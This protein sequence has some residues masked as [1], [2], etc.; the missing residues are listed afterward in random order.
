MAEIIGRKQ[1]IE[2]LNRLYHSDRAQFVAVY[3]RRRVGKTYLINQVFK[4]RITFHH[5]GLSPFDNNRKSTMKDQLQAFHYSLIRSGMDESTPCPKS[6]FE[7]FFLLERWLVKND[8]GQ[9]QVVFID[10]LPWMDTPRS[11]FLSALESFWNG[12]ASGCDNMFLVVCGS[13]TSW[14][15]SNLVNNYGGL[16]GRLTYE[17]KLSPFTLKECHDYL[18]SNGIKLGQYD[19]TQAYMVFGGIPYYLGYFLPGLSLAQNVDRLLFAKDAILAKEYD[20]LFHSLF[21]HWEEH[22]KVVQLLSTRHYGF[23]RDEISEHCGISKGGGLSSILKAL[24]DSDFIMKYSPVVD[25]RN[26]EYYRLCD[27][28]CL[29]YLKFV[30]D[31]KTTD[32]QFWQNNQNLQ[33]I[34]SWRGIAFEYVCFNHIAQIKRALGVSGVASRESALLVKGTKDLQGGQIDLLIDRADNVLNLCEMKFYKKEFSVTQSD[35]FDFEERI[36]LLNRLTK[37]KKNIHFTLVTTVGLAYNEH[38]GV[39]QKVVTLEDLFK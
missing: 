16:Y 9:R 26:V 29:F 10:E 25:E 22:Q 20:R 27:P 11:R 8:S 31:N 7:A 23:T 13:S 2:E 34:V 5:T 32:E 12:W 21:V 4:D 18:K 28:F 14:M 19:V 3:G 33:P 36:E 35:R 39:V 6:W 38:S 30:A 1:E 37:S 15:L 24:M 17:I